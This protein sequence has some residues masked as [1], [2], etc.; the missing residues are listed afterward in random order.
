MIDDLLIETLAY[1]GA[2]IGRHQGKAIFVPYTAPGDRVR[3]RVVREKK[4]YVVG[5]LVRLEVPSDRRRTPPCPVYGVCGGCQWQHMPY[6]E[7]ARWK[8]RIFSEALRR[9][10]GTEGPFLP[11]AKTDGE[12][13]YR[14]RVQF[15]CGQSA[16]AFVMGFYRRGSHSVVNIEHCPIAAAPINKALGLFRNWLPG[17]PRP[18][19]IS[20]VEMAVDDENGVRATV[21][22]LEAAAED[23]GAYLAPL[24]EEA[25][26]SLFLQSGRKDSLMRVRG[27][28]NL[29]IRPLA[30]SDLRL[31]Y[32]PGGFA[33]VNLEQN[34]E[35]VRSVRKA[36]G[37]TGR[38]R[39]L[40]LFCG[41]GNFSVPL[42]LDAE[43]VVGVEGYPP[44]IARARKNAA[45]NGVSNANFLVME[46]EGAVSALSRDRAFDLVVL[47]PPRTGAFGVTGELL[48][49][50]PK[51]ILYVSCDPPTLAR[52]LAPLLRGG[53]ELR[54]SRP[55]D[56]FPQTYHVE[57]VTLLTR[58]P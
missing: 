33:Q 52:D 9:G 8:E 16:G 29:W 1:G 10:C 22:C 5:E 18:D 37:L 3:C 54:W 4:R 53:Y 15:K 39:V 28:D 25:G 49:A 27:D 7:Q 47:D 26:L 20:Q 38:E 50:R 30:G 17:A 56:L 2:G 6:A 24:A 41:M 12:W 48:S 45:A 34:R 58:R 43:E 44:S 13:G 46:A 36:A 40:D 14:S 19:S 42:A 21:H 32:G 23:L 55:F 51:N 11:L 31:G 35:L 57:S